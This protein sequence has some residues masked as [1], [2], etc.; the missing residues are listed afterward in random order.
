M[1]KKG[2][3]WDQ[4]ERNMKIE[5]TKAD[6][7]S[8]GKSAPSEIFVQRQTKIQTSTTASICES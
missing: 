2:E 6:A 3:L 7:K 1:G 8:R 4:L 5:R